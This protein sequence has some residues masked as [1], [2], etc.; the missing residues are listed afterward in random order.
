VELEGDIT[1]ICC[2]ICM[3]VVMR[4]FSVGYIQR[5]ESCTRYNG[6]NFPR[7][8]RRACVLTYTGHFLKRRMDFEN[9]TY[10]QDEAHVNGED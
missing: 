3:H 8:R 9:E 4:G 6:S 5:K 1:W 10:L 7:S 2:R